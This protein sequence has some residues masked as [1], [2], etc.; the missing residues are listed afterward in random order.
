VKGGYFSQ[1]FHPPAPPRGGIIKVILKS[2]LGDLGVKEVC[3]KMNSI[4][5][6]FITLI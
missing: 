2:P 1:S 6:R 4:I 5:K 3:R